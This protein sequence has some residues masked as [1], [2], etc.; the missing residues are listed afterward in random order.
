V[1]GED[2]RYDPAI[3]KDKLCNLKQQKKEEPAW[4]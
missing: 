2:E 4:I 3:K 1:T